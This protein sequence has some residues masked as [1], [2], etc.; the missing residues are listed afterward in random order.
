M[1]IGGTVPGLV[2]F[3]TPLTKE[4]TDRRSAHTELCMSTFHWRE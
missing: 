2:R 1:F 3:P 4:V